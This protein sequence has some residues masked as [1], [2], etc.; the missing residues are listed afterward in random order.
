MDTLREIRSFALSAGL[1]LPLALASTGLSAQEK[2]KEH[3]DTPAAAYEPSMTTLGQ[4]Q[5]EIPGRKP[6]D[7]VITPSEFQ[8]ASK[9]YFERCAGRA[10]A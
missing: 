7:P 9:F 5:V 2:P 3:G 4:I 1:A 6:G 8:A 10:L